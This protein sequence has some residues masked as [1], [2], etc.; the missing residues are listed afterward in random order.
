M[1]AELAKSLRGS[2]ISLVAKGYGEARPVAPNTIKGKDN[3]RGRAENRRVETVYRNGPDSTPTPGPT[4]QPKPTTNETREPGEVPTPTKAYAT[5]TVKRG[6]QELV[7]EMY[8]VHRHGSLATLEFGVKAP[9]EG[10]RLRGLFAKDSV[11]YDEVTGVDL[12]DRPNKKRHLPASHGKECLCSVDFGRYSVSAGQTLYLSATYAA[13]E[14][15][16]T[17]VD[18]A[19]PRSG[20][21][22][23]VPVL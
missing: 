22:K 16:V 15:G 14:E 19:T 4:D 12:I 3:P 9:P 6:S 10:V 18:I 8:G 17:K 5:R 2:G 23:N 7:V 1:R 13:P 20:T 11:L 21:F